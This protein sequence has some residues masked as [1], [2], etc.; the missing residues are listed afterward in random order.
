MVRGLGLPPVQ[1]QAVMEATALVVVSQGEAVP[2]SGEAIDP[3]GPPPAY[4]TDWT[5]GISKVELRLF[6]A[7]EDRS[8]DVLDLRQV[9][10]ICPHSCAPSATFDTS[11]VLPQ[12]VWVAKAVATDVAKNV[13]GASDDLTILVV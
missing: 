2:I 4:L 13:S 1:R 7:L 9:L 12:G 5:S 3:I 8:T 11:V 10:D 6:N